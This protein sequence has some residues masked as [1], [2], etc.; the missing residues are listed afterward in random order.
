LEDLAVSLLLPAQELTNFT[1]HS[2]SHA[3]NYSASGDQL[4]QVALE[5]ATTIT[6]WRFLRGVSVLAP[7]QAGTL[8]CFGDSITDG[9][10]STAD[11]NSRWPDNLST[12]LRSQRGKGMT[13]VINE[14]IGGNQ[15]LHDGTGPAALTR[16]PRDVLS[17]DGVQSVVILEGINDIAHTNA[18]FPEFYMPVTA[19]DIIVGLK[20]LLNQAHAHG[21]K[22]YAGTL[23]P[24]F[25]SKYYWPGGEQIRLAVNTYIR[26]SK[27][28][29]GVIDFDRLLADPVNPQALLPAY[30]H[31]DHLHPSDAGYRVMANGIEN[32]I[33]RKSGRSAQEKQDKLRVP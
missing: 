13:A 31:G 20:A 3:T 19:A 6:P 32:T 1:Q 5:N 21:L 9:T 11:A 15:I 8:I 2:A 27:A 28:F 18:T 24:Y 17:Q 25:G 33:F 12:W 14:G 7:H 23:T 10:G 16:F 29:D 4:M 30:E 26:G 22:V